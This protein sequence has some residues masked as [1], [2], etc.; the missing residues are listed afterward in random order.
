[1][2]GALP[3]SMSED[4]TSVVERPKSVS[5]TTTLRSEVP[6]EDSARPSVTIK[7]SGLMSR[8]N[9]FWAWQAATA[10]HIWAN[11][12][13]MR[14]RRV[15]ERSCAGWRL[16]SRLGVGGV[17]EEGRDGSKSGS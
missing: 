9:T 2:Y 5:L 13:A 10:S 16:E 3:Q 15:R 11:M 17:Q 8:W 6:L 12:E 4:S 7:F 14:R 1:M